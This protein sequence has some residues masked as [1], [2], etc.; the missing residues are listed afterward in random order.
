MR[1]HRLWHDRPNR[2]PKMAVL[3]FDELYGN[4]VCAKHDASTCPQAL[5]RTICQRQASKIQTLQALRQLKSLRETAISANP[6][7]V[8]YRRCT[9]RAFS[10][11]ESPQW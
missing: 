1:A 2:R 3:H 7:G 9:Q 5:E 6:L 11:L 4:T 10:S 8:P